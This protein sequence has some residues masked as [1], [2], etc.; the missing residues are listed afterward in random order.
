MRE[1]TDGADLEGYLRRPQQ[2]KFR[3]GAGRLC[4]RQSAEVRAANQAPVLSSFGRSDDAERN[5]RRRDPIS[6]AA[7][8]GMA[9]AMNTRAYMVLQAAAAAG[10]IV[11]LHRMAS[12]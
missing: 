11:F 3:Q 5:H 7:R 6:R 10:F 1:C 12:G 2:G 9:G 4:L 8:P